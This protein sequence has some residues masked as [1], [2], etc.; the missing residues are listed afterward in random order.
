MRI[1]AVY[2]IKGGVG[3]T[4]AA[5]N[6]AYLSASSGARTL[7]WDL[8][9]Q[10]AATYCFRVRPKIKGG[11]KK[12]VRSKKPVHRLIRGTDYDALDLLPSDFSY[13]NLDLAL[14]ASMRPKRSLG[15]LIRPL[16][17]RYDH[18]YIDCAPGISL[19]SEGVFLAAD[20]LLVPT[21][22]TTLSLRTLE[23]L[24]RHLRRKG[25]ADLAVLPFFSMVDGR[26]TIHREVRDNPPAGPFPFLGTSI[27]YS[28]VA[29]QMSIERRP[30]HEFAPSSPAARAFEELWS[31]VMS[32]TSSF[33]SW[34][35]RW[36]WRR[37]SAP[38]APFPPGSRQAKRAGSFS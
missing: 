8:D 12:L 36:A 16:Q 34:I 20:A 33:M 32:R 17:D 25:P 15:R 28:S 30:L 26:K 29:E 2:N 9:P 37:E 4:T 19:V 7:L 18:V 38:S 27:A 31:E 13:R 22:P 11:A 10:G 6:L 14:D 23:Q 35:V 21:I 3:K 1:L 24:D 5:V